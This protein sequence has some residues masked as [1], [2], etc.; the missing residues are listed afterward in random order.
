MKEESF[1]SALTCAPVFLK[2]D[3]RRSNGMDVAQKSDCRAS[4]GFNSTFSVGDVLKVLALHYLLHN[5]VGVHAG[6]VHPGGV[7]LYRVLLP[8]KIEPTVTSARR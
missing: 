4:E 1:S 6:V 7:A 5:G 3:G 8:P 2:A